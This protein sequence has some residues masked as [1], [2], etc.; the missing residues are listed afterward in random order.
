MMHER[1]DHQWARNALYTTLLVLLV[2][3]PLRAIDDFCFLQVSDIHIDPQPVGAPNPGPD[4]R[5]VSTLEWFCR[6]AVKPQ[7]L[8]PL[9]LTAPKPEFVIAT[10]DLTEYG[11]IHK[12]WSNFESY[13][14]PLDL[15]LYVTPGNHDNT[16]TAM[17]PIMRK[18]YGGDN[19]AFERHGCHF[20]GFDSSTPQEPVP[21]I[22]RRS[23]TFIENYLGNVDARA[24]V[25]LFCHHPLSST[26]FAKPHEQLRLLDALKDHNAV[27]LLMGHGHGVHHESWA[28]LDSVMGGSTFGPNTGYSTI[29]VIND[30]LRVVYRYRDESKPPV[31][32]LEKL[33]ISPP[34]PRLSVEPADGTLG[35]PL[36]VV[37]RIETN[38]PQPRLRSMLQ[39][40]GAVHVSLDDVEARSG[41]LAPGQNANLAEPMSFKGQL[42]TDEL[43][44]GM[45]FVRVT[46]KAGKLELDAAA[47][48]RIEPA[49]GPR[50]SRV[51]MDAGMK[52]TPLVLSGG[53]V[54]VANTSGRLEKVSF[55]DEAGTS[56]RFYVENGP[57]REIL[58]A[59][60]FDGERFYIA[61]AETGVH[62]VDGEGKQVWQYP[63][64]AAVYGTPALGEKAVYVADLEGW[65]HAIN[66]TDG[67]P[68][69]RKSFATFSF[70]MPP[71][72][73]DGVIYAGAW[74]GF[75]YAVHA[76]SGELKW[77]TRTPAGQSAGK[78]L[79]RYYAGA[80]CPPIIIGDRLFMAD[81][82]YY[83]GSYSL[84]D[85][86]YFGDIA[87]DVCA[88]GLS[89]NGKSFY[90]RGQEKLIKFDGQGKPLWEQK[91][92]LGRFPIPPT[93][94]GGRVYACSNRGMLYILDAADGAE[95]YRYQA[96]PQLHVMAGVAVAA[97]GAAIVADMDGAVMRI[98]LPDRLVSRK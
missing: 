23:L 85:G 91:I 18:R 26:E 89:E 43:V 93:E 61:I 7:S 9:D 84:E 65:M 74:D 27:L 57:L 78:Y 73:H 8:K 30:T 97:D 53:E 24:P 70:E 62:C 72:L 81:R 90:S 6:E 47:T 87:I 76:E 49:D 77:K 41:V 22:D 42:S 66:R 2:T 40:D 67:K 19:Y 4:A 59:P 45:H 52:A 3:S 16:W 31:V 48:T 98:P 56:K 21:S 32:L 86:K 14:K 71:L 80:D 5:S 68:L 58:H 82:A 10:G 36:K 1:T 95:L 69:W 64:G 60:A 50:S 96:S 20:I 88:V 11:V 29:S 38:R 15:P 33:I 25:F 51:Q 44:P 12:T 54:M 75:L 35:S 46:A 13:F 17:L 28:G 34:R 55:R 94:R 83:L 63:T 39:S 92:T 37:A 79:S